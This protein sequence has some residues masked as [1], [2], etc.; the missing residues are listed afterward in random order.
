[1]K[2]LRFNLENSI[3]GMR[4]YTFCSPL[5]T[6]I[7]RGLNAIW[8]QHQMMLALSIHLGFKLANPGFEATNKFC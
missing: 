6:G 3:I 5:L 7:L 4:R 2:L 1:M 8:Q